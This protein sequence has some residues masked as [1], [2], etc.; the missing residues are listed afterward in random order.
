MIMLTVMMCH[1]T[2]RTAWLIQCMVR[3]II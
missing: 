2:A 3:S 1:A